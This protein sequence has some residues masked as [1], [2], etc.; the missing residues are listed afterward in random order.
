MKHAHFHLLLLIGLLMS[1]YSYSQKH[2]K[3]RLAKAESKVR[4]VVLADRTGGEDRGIFKEVVDQMNTLCP[5]FVVSVGDV[6]DGYTTDQFYLNNL[7][8]EFDSLTTAI[9]VPL[10]IAPGN[11]DV[12]N[13]WM[14]NQ[15]KKR[16]GCT[17][18]AVDV[19]DDLLLFLNT[20]DG[21]ASCISQQQV[22]Y[23]RHALNEYKK[24]GWIYLFMHRPLWKYGDKG[25]YEKI[26]ELLQHAKN[27]IVFSGHEHHYVMNNREGRRHYMLSTSGGG[28][29][30]RS[31]SLG[32][33]HHFFFVTMDKEEPTV[34]NILLN[35]VV[36]ERIV[37]ELN[38]TTVSVMRNESWFHLKPTLLQAHKQKEV[39][40]QLLLNNDAAVSI[41]IRGKLPS[42]SSI[43]FAP[44]EI[45]T[46]LPAQSKA[47]IKLSM[48]NSAGVNLLSA[49][50][51]IALEA[52]AKVEQD[53]PEIVTRLEKEWVVD[54]PRIIQSQTTP[55]WINV[56]PGYIKEDW[57]WKGDDDGRFCFALS[58][59]QRNLILEINAIDDQ[60]ILHP[61][62]PQ[63]L[64]DKLFVKIASGDGEELGKTMH[65]MC[66]D[67]NLFLDDNLQQIKEIK[68]TVGHS[69]GKLSAKLILPKHL[70][71]D[72]CHRIRLNV[73]FMDHDNELNTKPSVL[74]WNTLWHTEQE[75]K[76]SGIFLLNN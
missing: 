22:D 39:S 43:Q 37:N 14:E 3:N 74:W 38:E 48:L 40:T 5:D 10:Y 61:N 58:A 17:Y 31:N 16:F 64:Q 20:D 19:N 56:R 73:G 71:G 33:F 41:R 42:I 4:F 34:S 45:D 44:S 21:G 7:W 72:K 51:K 8:S 23:F 36:P 32:E 6:I 27:V 76:H 2:N 35:G 11:H 67:G 9:K 57:D 15:W 12:S 13:P 25:G 26:E 1:S 18:Q 49:P 69:E 59:N 50:I 75:N 52:S 54:V 60:L 53:A 28:N 62:D 29:N 68:G 24:E 65:I 63:R 30:L 55:E 66:V 46:V 70:F 47:T